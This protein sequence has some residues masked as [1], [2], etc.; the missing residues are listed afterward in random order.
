MENFDFTSWERRKSERRKLQ[1][2]QRILRSNFLK[3]LNT[4]SE[5]DFA[6]FALQFQET[7][8]EDIRLDPFLID[9]EK[10][11]IAFYNLFLSLE[12]NIYY[13]PIPRLSGVEPDNRF[14]LFAYDN[15]RAI[16]I[17]DNPAYLFA[18]LADIQPRSPIPIIGLSYNSLAS[19]RIA[20]STGQ[21]LFNY[22][23][24]SLK[25]S[26][27]LAGALALGHLTISLDTL[28][29]AI[30][31]NPFYQAKQLNQ[32][33]Q[34]IGLV[35]FLRPPIDALPVYG[36]QVS[37]NHELSYNL[38]QFLKDA[39]KTS[40]TGSEITTG[41]VTQAKPDEALAD[42]DY[43]LKELKKAK[44]IKE[45]SHDELSATMQGTAY[46]RSRVLPFPLGQLLYYTCLTA[47]EEVQK[48][49]KV[50]FFEA[51][52]Q[53]TIQQSP[54]DHSPLFVSIDDIDNFAAVNFFPVSSIQVKLPLENSEAEIKEL[55]QRIIGDPFTKTD[56]GGEQNDIFSSRVVR[57]GKRLLAAFFLKGPSVKGRLTL[58]KCGKNGDQIQRLFQSP[59][60]MFVV[61]FN[62]EID[63]RV[64][65]E[66]RQKVSHLRLT[67]N[68]NAFFTVID[69]GDTARLMAAYSRNT[70]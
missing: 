11:L 23:I 33:A 2:R 55:L 27:S 7:L 51:I 35:D 67:Q 3:Q 13:G 25:K 53:G 12:F 64:I 15:N 47:R 26:K 19:N 4:L 68:K 54:Q 65:E 43:Y 14:P 31:L 10:Y 46:L 45:S 22:S 39:D 37:S 63:E 18:D 32:L 38:E 8:S 1:R 40:S 56:W 42:P 61:Q 69:G 17:E 59:A 44:L 60:D 5:N 58:A 20:G 24:E 29:E 16:L 62:G 9:T 48:V 52:K 28:R 21:R 70:P 50:A 34:R 57:N 41:D 6:Q 30:S 49:A 66:C 36:Q